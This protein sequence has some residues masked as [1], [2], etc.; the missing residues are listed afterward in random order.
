MTD[1]SHF[2][3]LIVVT[4]SDCE[5]VLPLYPRL[6]QNFDY[7]NLCFIGAPKV[8]EIA[9]N[10]AI[11]DHADWVDENDIIPF[12]DV[13]ACMT[14]R[15]SSIIGDEPLPRGITGWYYQQFLKMQY[16][17]ICEN[18]Y[19]MVWDGDTVPC[20]KV[21]M[22][23]PETGQP[24]L[25]LKHEYHPEYFE[26]M[27]K[28]LPGFGK[29]I[30]RSFISEHML[31][32]CDIMRSLIADIEKND[33]IPGEKFWE[34]IINSIEPAKMS[35]S[36]FSEFETYG[37]YVALRY[38]SVYKL[39]E[40]HSFRLGASFFDMNTICDRDF[41]WLGRDF[42]AISFEKGQS[43]VE[44]NR[45]YFDNPEVQQKISAK[46]LLQAA[47]MEYKDGYK[48]V[49]ED[50]IT[51]S[52][53]ANVRSGGYQQSQGDDNRT[54]IVIVS[55]NSCH[56]MEKNLESIRQVL[57]LGTYKIVVVDNASDD[58]VE[59]YL[60][61]QQDIIF[62]RNEENVG[63][64]PAC[65]QAVNATRG[66][67]F[68]SYDVFLLNNDTR[69][70]FDSLYFLRKALYSAEDIGAVGS[71]SN[72]AGNKQQLDVTFDKV[73][74]YIAFG[75]KN[76]VPMESPCLERVRLS[77]FAMLIRRKVWDEIGGFDEDFAPG[78]FEDDA[79]SMEILKK[80][81]RL[82]LVRN[83]FI[84]HAG[85]QSFI[86]TDYKKLLEDHHELFKQKYGFDILDYAY[87]SGTV[88]SQ[89]PYGPN[90]RFTVLHY[91]CGLGAELKAIRSIFPNTDLYG[92]ETNLKIQAIVKRTEQIFASVDE[93]LEFINTPF[94]NVLIIDKDE[95]NAM[96]ESLQ[97]LLSGL[98]L[99]NASVLIK[100]QKYE[101]FPYEKIKLIIWDMDDTFWQGI[102]SEGEVIL[103]ITN[104][105]L[106][107]SITDHGVLNS[108]SS[109]NDEAP[110]ME[111]LERAGI[112]DHFV[113]NNINWEEKGAQIAA[114][115]SAMGLRPENVLFID[116]NP[117]NL[118]E[119]R[120]HAADIMTAMPDIIPYLTTFFARTKATDTE[121]KRLN[122][123]K[124]LEKKTKAQ[125]NSTSKEDF[126]KES[127]IRIVINRNC[128]EKLDRIHELVMRS[129]QLNFTKNRD[130]KEILTRFITNDWNDCG[131]IEARDRFGDYGI[132]GFF[133]YNTREKKMEHFL[134]SCRVLGMG[135]EQYIY[136]KLGCPDF[137]VKEPVSVKLE[138]DR[139]IDY[140]TEEE[141][142]EVKD[143]S[144]AKGK[145]RIL[146]KGPCDLDSIEPYLSG[147]SIT[148]E[149]NYI[150]DRGF[151][152]TGQ[153]H[154]MHIW[155][156]ANLS[157][158][159]ISCITAEVPF[160]TE[161]DFLTK[162]F[163]E[164]YHVICFSMMTDLAAAL[165]KRKD[166]EEYIAFSNRNQI[167]TDPANKEGF[168]SGKLQGHGFPFTEEIIDRFSE[169]WE[170]VGVT[171]IDLLFRNLDFI[172]DNVKG[173]PLFILL[174]G[175]EIDYEGSSPEFDG[176]GEVYRQYNPIIEEFASDHD[177]MKIVN[178]TQ[179]INS[180]ND[181]ADAI[182]HF[183]R[184]VYYK[185]AGEIAR[186]I[187]EFV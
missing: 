35:D 54:L 102:L 60:A 169:N 127:D 93:L 53:G 166:S 153:N 113:F 7:G 140:I 5:R 40:W 30:E 185:I 50:D 8:G 45:G 64:G 137:E 159:Q 34:K 25:D 145:V 125:V 163:Y 79:L 149:F 11:K 26:T 162:L 71:V 90:D 80:G 119:A 47:Q 57:T 68:E 144:A 52:K 61:G 86:K 39:R 172:Y 77:G 164:E 158:E 120:F 59:K 69:L 23:S 4:P 43:I 184:N 20:R 128:L 14:K 32:R 177:R 28:L 73:E 62:I 152:T 157:K 109:K 104:A 21:N 118:E 24:Y 167:L 12:D 176:L 121:H 27:G 88:I 96:D 1:N 151:V 135:I 91:G 9:K 110:V 161:G 31:F 155:E 76:N 44:E 116:D 41:E 92:I 115:I 58:G 142:L 134:F 139:A 33:S 42:D 82:Q 56:L 143:D 84:Y 51:V 49:W 17:A 175:S 10:S 108:I 99:P 126:L 3:V 147:A 70:V 16:S 95:L 81:Y 103:P 131:Y 36:C 117:R 72:Y 89:I 165:Y 133:C 183:S 180:Q 37:T 150:N 179:F 13:H 83:S 187:N 63:F 130:N 6:V 98:L 38:P 122:Q 101:T 154:S 66:T 46:R 171:P 124:I 105:D 107:R 138:K 106:I 136:N 173:K 148:S 114:K 141:T 112:A 48:E 186:Y 100:D 74:D 132:I 19:Y 174:L 94:F 111:E 65:N 181:F 87:A 67:E 55:Y 146:L 18:E 182:N 97:T 78:Y 85:S 178:I 29:V 22:F 123:Y 160:I 129:N 75:E 170:Y 15:L 168:I 156:S 2:D